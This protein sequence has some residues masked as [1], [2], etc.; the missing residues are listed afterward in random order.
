LIGR[1]TPTGELTEFSSLPVSPNPYAIVAGRDGYL[2]FSG[3]A[4]TLG[5]IVP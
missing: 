1:L 2:W 5:R 3:T 4:G